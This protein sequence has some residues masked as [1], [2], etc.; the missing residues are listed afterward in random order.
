MLE[1]THAASCETFSLKKTGDYVLT[2]VA[3]NQVMTQL[4]LS[5]YKEKHDDEFDPRTAWYTSGP[6]SDLAYVFSRL[7]KGQDAT[8]EFRMWAKRVSFEGAGVTDV[9]DV[10][11]KKDGDV[12]AIGR[13]GYV[14]DATLASPSIH[15]A[16][17]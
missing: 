14:G 6:W 4:P 12:I 9:Y 5:V 7:D 15:H 1:S 8:V 17:S 10:D 13:T 3:G 2:F 16:T 11:L